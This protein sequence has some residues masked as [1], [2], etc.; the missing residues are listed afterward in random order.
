MAIM[1]LTVRETVTR[2][3]EEGLPVSENALRAWIRSGAVPVRRAGRKLLIYYPNLVRYLQCE[4]GCDNRPA[5]AAML[6][7]IRRID[8]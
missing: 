7:G 8:L 3:K 5:T 6:P 1:M 2:A 4:D